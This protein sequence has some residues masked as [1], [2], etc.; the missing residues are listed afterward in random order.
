VAK[1]VEEFGPYRSGKP[2]RHP[3]TISTASFPAACEL[4]PFAFL[5]AKRLVQQAEAPASWRYIFL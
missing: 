4:V 5:P 1:A 2:L 3:R